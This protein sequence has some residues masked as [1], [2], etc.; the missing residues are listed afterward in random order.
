MEASQALLKLY[1][2]RQL[3]LPEALFTLN[4]DENAVEQAVDALRTRF[5]TI[6]EVEDTVATGD[7][8]QLLLPVV[9]EQKEKTVQVNVGRHFYDAPFEDA[10]IG[11]SLGDVFTMPARRDAGRTGTLLSIK[12]RMLPELSDRLVERMEIEG[13]TTLEAYREME[14]QAT[15]QADKAKKQRALLGMVKREAMKRSTFGEL[16]AQIRQRLAD[17]ERDLRMVAEM[18]GMSYE[19]FRAM[20][21]PEQYDT[22]E[23]QDAYWYEKS[24]SD[25]KLKLVA[26]TFVA[27]AGKAFTQE[28]YENKCKELLSVGATQE[29]IDARYPFEAFMEA[30]PVEYYEKSIAAYYED[31]FHVAET[32]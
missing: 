31:R 12:R 23:K 11:A 5:L 24:E 29:Q 19:E 3:T 2:F 30:A 13:V 16:E 26:D 17:Y 27:E 4:W 7:I 18:N 1:D 32:K 22:P 6:A 9:G 8:V 10:L 21:T 15:I 14:K 25:I 20:N 28:E